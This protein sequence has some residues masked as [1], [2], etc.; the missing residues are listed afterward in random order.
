[1]G[2]ILAS[3]MCVFIHIFIYKIKLMFPTHLGLDFYLHIS[4]RK[5]TAQNVKPMN[6]KKKKN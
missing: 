1:M 2:E 5:M 4:T 6:L 3:I